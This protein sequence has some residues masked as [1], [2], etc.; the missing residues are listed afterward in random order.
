MSKS[1][2]KFLLQ[3]KLN[4]NTHINQKICYIINDNH[5]KKNIINYKKTYS[6]NILKI[7]DLCYKNKN[8]P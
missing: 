8:I 1:M 2:V 4:K 7:L 6:S 5:N 3:N